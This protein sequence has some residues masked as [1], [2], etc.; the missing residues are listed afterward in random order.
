M[1]MACPERPGARLWSRPW[2]V[3]FGPPTSATS[4]PERQEGARSTDASW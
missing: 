4:P 1:L 3:V 2:P